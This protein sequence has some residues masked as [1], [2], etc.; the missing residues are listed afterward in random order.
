MVN[1]YDQAELEQLELSDY[2]FLPSIDIRLIDSMGPIVH[3][4][5]KEGTYDPE[6]EEL[7]IDYSKLRDYFEIIVVQR[8]RL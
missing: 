1:L 6:M 8:E 3:N 5:L 2:T 4:I 7:I